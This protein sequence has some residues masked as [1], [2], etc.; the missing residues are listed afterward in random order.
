MSPVSVK[1]TDG[2]GGEGM[3]EQPKSIMTASAWSSINHSILSGQMLQSVDR[4]TVT[5]PTTIMV[6]LLVI[7]FR[8]GF[9]PW[10][11]FP[12]GDSLIIGMASKINYAL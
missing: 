10:Q 8:W 1:L 9:S 4:S 11:D 7:T 3:G 12:P 2:G 6:F 5:H